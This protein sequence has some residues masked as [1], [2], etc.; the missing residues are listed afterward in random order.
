MCFR[1]MEGS[2]VAIVLV[3]H[4]DDIFVVGETER[5][6]RFA[7]DLNQ[8]IPTKNLGG[9]GGVQGVFMRE[10]ER[11]EGSRFLSRR[12]SRSWQGSTE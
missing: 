9:S 3:F 1:L 12:M 2:K 4:V 11:Q 10:T 5:C 6:D 8:S 7:Q